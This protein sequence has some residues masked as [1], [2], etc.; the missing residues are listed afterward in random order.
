LEPFTNQNALRVSRQNRYNEE[1]KK[2]FAIATG[3]LRRHEEACLIAN[4][5]N[6]TPVTQTSAALVTWPKQ[7]C[8]PSY[9][10]EQFCGPTPYVLGPKIQSTDI[11]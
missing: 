6:V 8:R 1:K 5:F 10:S 7:A 4:R 9:V 3:A 2:A 11:R